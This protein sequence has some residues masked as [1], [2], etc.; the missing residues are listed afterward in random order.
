MGQDWFVVLSNR[1]KEWSAEIS[2]MSYHH[3]ELKIKIDSVSR[4][5]GYKTPKSGW[6]KFIN[7][8]F[9]LK[10]LSLED[11]SKLACYGYDSPTD[12]CS[13]SI[14]IATKNTYRYYYY[15]NPDYYSGRYW[16]ANNVVKLLKLVNE[17]LSI[18]SDWPSPINVKFDTINSLK[19]KM[20]EI[21]LKD[22]NTDSAR[23]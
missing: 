18:D 7:K 15:L 10:I 11:C 13:V 19:I 9:N 14:E 4:K 16:Q 21:E 12:G 6:S 3:N 1:N 8:L 23:N 17:E 22:V 20:S 5:I 2:K